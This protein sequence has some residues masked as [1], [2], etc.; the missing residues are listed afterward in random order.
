MSIKVDVQLDCKGIA[1]PMPIIRTKKAIDQL[2]HGKVIEV[3]ATDPGLLA[4]FKGW[5]QS[6]GHQ[7]LGAKKEGEIFKHYIRKA[8]DPS[9][10]EERKYLHVIKNE[11][12]LKKLDSDEAFVLL[13]VREPAEYAFGHLPGACSIPYGELEERI[14]ELPKESPIYVICHTGHRSDMA[15][16]LLTKHGF[17]HVVNVEP[18]MSQWNGPIEGEE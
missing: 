5:A 13:D 11:E 10:K 1:C 9:L 7:Y 15:A 4:D 18:G 16:Q 3:Q 2:E 8:S 12:L 17:K 6:T 14:N